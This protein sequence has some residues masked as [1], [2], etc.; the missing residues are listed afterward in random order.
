MQVTAGPDGFVSTSA[1]AEYPSHVLLTEYLNERRANGGQALE[2]A[3]PRF[4][5]RLSK[6]ELVALILAIHA[7]IGWIAEHERE[8]A[9]PG[10][11]QDFLAQL[12]RNLYSASLPFSARDLITLLQGHRKHRSLWWFGPEELLVTY[13]ETHDFLPELAAE[14]RNFQA[15]LTGFPG[16]M[17]YQNQAGYQVAVQ[18]I[19]MLLWHD[20]S[21]PLDLSRCWSEAVRCD[22]RAMSGARRDHWK[23]LFRHIKGNA[24]AKPAKG[25]LK[26]A[27]K[28]LAQVG[29]VD[30]R[31]RFCA[32]LAPFRS[33]QPQP[34]SVPGSHIL[35]GLLWYST[36]IDD[37]ALAS[38][39]L[40]LLDATWKAKRNVD[41]V[42]VALVG[43]LEMLPPPEA[44]PP[45]LRLQQE[46]PTSSVQVE[47]LLKHTAGRFGITEEELK[48]RA[49]LK[50]KLDLTEQ[51]DRVMERLSETRA[52]I[53][54]R[55]PR[56]R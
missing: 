11:W 32:W 6:R 10:R 18:H 37:P 38:V 50:P 21:D 3:L 17:K 46:W 7:R 45:L 28:R 51:V 5:K 52:M 31:D 47:R 4:R 25:W 43:V 48:A 40:T 22:L 30:F 14:L 1:V 15:E 29:V 26:E 19:H 27:E 39:A 49:L 35:R 55:D 12:A 54:I 53:R 24:P 2:C 36:L 41:K 20:E 23:A 34:L 8:L 33:S 42:M 9:E 56:G 16:G 13:I 44:W